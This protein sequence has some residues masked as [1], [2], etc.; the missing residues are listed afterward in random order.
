MDTEEG[1]LICH[2]GKLQFLPEGAVMKRLAC[3]TTDYLF[4][5]KVMCD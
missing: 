3:R 2:S 1:F 4:F 5:H